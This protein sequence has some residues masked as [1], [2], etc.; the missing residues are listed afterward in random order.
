MTIAELHIEVKQASQNIAAS[1]RRKLL[2]EEIDWLLNK[3]QQRFIQSKI[4]AK[5]DGSGGFQLDQLNADAIRPL[6]TTADLIAVYDSNEQSYECELPGDYSYLISDDSRVTKLCN[7]ITGITSTTT[8]PILAI[9][10]PNSTATGPY[11]ATVSITINGDTLTLSTLIASQVASYT[12]LSSVQEK[13]IIRDFLLWQLRKAGYEVYWEKYMDIYKPSTFLLPNQNAGSITIDG[14][15]TNGTVSTIDFSYFSN[16]SNIWRANRLTPGDQVSTM[17][18]TAFV[19]TSYQSP[20]SELWGNKLIVHGDESFIISK[21][22]IDYIRKPR[23]M[24][25]AL[26]ED[27]E[28]PEEFHQSLCDLT[29]EYFKAMTADTNWEVKLKDNMLRSAPIQ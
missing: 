9:P 1:T 7:G 22:R 26:G 2:P 13:Y 21:A 28:L 27:C 24:C 23:R 20:I 16:S 8:Q 12:G 25:L 4:R 18:D 19:T 29:V 5:K 15:T 10:L 6:L 11:Y 14:T 17:L 3:N